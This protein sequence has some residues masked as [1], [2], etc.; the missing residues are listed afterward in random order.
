MLKTFSHKLDTSI[1]KP[2]LAQPELNSVPIRNL[3][4]KHLINHNL[5]L[6]LNSQESVIDLDELDIVLQQSARKIVTVPQHFSESLANFN[7]KS[8]QFYG[9]QPNLNARLNGDIQ[10]AMKVIMD[11]VPSPRQ[12]LKP[13]KHFKSDV[14]LQQNSELTNTKVMANLMSRHSRNQVI[15]IQPKP[16]IFSIKTPAKNFE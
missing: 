8:S 9:S 5:V 11:T 15:F 12:A 13:S 10:N 1:F 4:S 2:T 14:V 3:M 16:H 6:N 7:D